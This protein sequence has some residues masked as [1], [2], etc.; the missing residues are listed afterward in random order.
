MDIQFPFA[1]PT[2]PDQYGINQPAAQ[3][4]DGINLRSFPFTVNDL[5]A[6]AQT[7]AF[8][9]IDHDTIPIVGYS[10]IHWLGANLPV[11]D[12]TVVVPVAASQAESFVQGTNS[13]ANIIDT[14]RQPAAFRQQGY[15]LTRHYTG[16][17]PQGGTHIF[18]LDVYALDVVLPLQN[19]YLYNE[20]LRAIEGHVCQQAHAN[21]EYTRR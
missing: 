15:D 10:W 19:G 18:R 17:R 16:P 12:S 4:I 7:V 21:L 20:F 8:S 3:L 5:P 6:T 14:I 11:R 1:L 2:L 9:V 13:M